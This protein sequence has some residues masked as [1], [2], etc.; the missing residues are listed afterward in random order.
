LALELTE[1]LEYRSLGSFSIT[2]SRDHDFSDGR[3]RRHEC[4]RL[5]DSPRLVT[6]EGGSLA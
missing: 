6:R 5:Q 4:L 2:D 1:G 3:V